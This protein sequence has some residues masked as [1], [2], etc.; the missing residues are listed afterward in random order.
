MKK[1]ELNQLKAKAARKA[2]DVLFWMDKKNKSR[3]NSLIAIRAMHEQ[4][5]RLELAEL[6]E[7]IA[8]ES[9]RLSQ[10]R[11][12]NARKVFRQGLAKILS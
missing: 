9:H 10:E 7:A 2:E 12:E 6:H 3:K 8:A 5:C 11:L 4:R 1:S